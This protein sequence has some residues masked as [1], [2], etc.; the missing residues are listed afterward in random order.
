[1]KLTHRIA[2]LDDF[3]A[4]RDLMSMAIEQLQT[5]FLSPEQI[6]ASKFVMGLDSLL[7]RDQTYFVI[8]AGEVMAGCG[9]WSRRK[10]LFGGD[11]TQGRDPDLLDPKIDA[12]RVRAMYTHP[13]YTRRG[14]GTLILQLCEQAARKEGFK[15]VELAA[16]MAGV[17]LYSHYGFLEIGRWMEKT[18]S[19][20]EVPL[21]KMVK[22][23]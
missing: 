3:D 1:M 5:E 4:M 8:M 19:G 17:P 11:H 6:E 14:I 9:G 2:T 7:V 20:V 13:D 23:I 18:P 16:T 21:A 12:A 10:T 15:K 22:D